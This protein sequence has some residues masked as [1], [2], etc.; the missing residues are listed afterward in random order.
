MKMNVLFYG[1]PEKLRDSLTN[2]FQDSEIRVMGEVTQAEQVNERL[3][4]DRP[5]VLFLYE[6]DDRKLFA[7]CQQ[8]Y[9]LYPHCMMLMLGENIDINIQ[10]QAYMAGVRAVLSPVPSGKEVVMLVKSL[11][12]SENSRLSGVVGRADTVRR[13][14]TICM[15]SAK[16][17]VGKTTAAVSLAAQ[18]AMEK[19]K[20]ALLDFNLQFGDLS[21]FL[22]IDSGGTL[23]ELL[24]E[25]K[26]PTLDII[27]GY[28]MFH[29]SGLRVLL[30]PSNPEHGE[31]IAPKS[32]EKIVLLLQNYYDYI[33]IDT[34]VGFNDIN[35]AMLD[36]ASTILVMA[37]PDLCTLRNTKKA[38]LLLEDLEL[39]N[40]IKLV[41]RKNPNTSV[42]QLDVERILQQKVDIMLEYDSRTA[43]T[44][45]N[46]GKPVVMT[47]QNSPLTKSLKEM[48]ELLDVNTTSSEDK[49][50]RKVQKEKRPFL[51]RKGR[52]S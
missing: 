37:E 2:A 29:P 20:V 26:D 23:S 17:G 39:R 41:L 38:L 30:A 42:T 44:A 31:S 32:L 12:I 40:R 52:R 25:Q 34:A 28:L 19:K 27:N 24:M 43:M 5:D 48:T 8:I 22:G 47:A 11:L 16:G 1:V 51:I 21:L 9:V 46:Q 3:E 10:N 6:S 18:L 50:I 14:E 49:T 36:M 45:I 13:T 4:R 15:F 33:I 35:L 7:M